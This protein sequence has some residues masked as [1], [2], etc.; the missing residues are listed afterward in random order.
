VDEEGIVR[1]EKDDLQ[2]LEAEVKVLPLSRLGMLI[3]KKNQKLIWAA[4][5]HR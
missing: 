2:Q 1:K 3:K 4:P 5:E